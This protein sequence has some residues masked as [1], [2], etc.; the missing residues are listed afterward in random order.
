MAEPVVV[1]V[2]SVVDPELR[3]SLNWSPVLTRL[4]TSF[5]MV[6]VGGDEHV[7]RSVV[8][9]LALFTSFRLVKP[10]MSYAVMA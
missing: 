10:G 5:S 4:T 9:R 7:A 3:L 8:P 2:A 1:A 6:I